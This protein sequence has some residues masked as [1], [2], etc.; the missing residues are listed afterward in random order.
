MA[1]TLQQMS[2]AHL[3]NVQR[4]IANLRENHRKIEDEIKRL[5]EYFDEG[6][7]ALN[8]SKATET[9]TRSQNVSSVFEG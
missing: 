4:E 9:V 6:V 8:E 1:I 3:L 7:K 5:T 2:E